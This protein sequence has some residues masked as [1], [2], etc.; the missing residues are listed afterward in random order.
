MTF[1]F[2]L[3]VLV[4]LVTVAMHLVIDLGLKKMRRLKDVEVLSGSAPAVTVI[5]PACNEADTIGP[6]LNSI[7]ALEYPDLEIIV[8]NDRSTDGTGQVLQDLQK[9]F[10]QL[11]IL[12][13]SELPPGWLG[14]NHALHVAAARSGGDFLLFT[15]ADV[16]FEK[17]S[18]ARAMHHMLTERLDH[19]S[20]VFENTACGGLLNAL[21]MDAGGGLLLL[22]RPWLARETKSRRYMGVGAFNLVKKSVYQRIGGHQ[23]IAM[24]PIDDIMLG[25]LIKHR[26]F[27]QDCLLGQGFVSVRWYGTVHEFI[28][29]L[30]KN[31]FAVYNYSVAKA[32]ATV[33]V[34]F[35]LNG[36][37]QLGLLFAEGGTRSFFAAT[38]AV[39]FLSFLRGA[40]QTDISPWYTPWTLVSPYIIAYT[41]IKATFLTLYNR[42]IYWRGTFYP[43]DR[44][45]AG[46]L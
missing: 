11:R 29:G 14:K 1:L 13:I 42:G 35:L 44:L 19:M 34:L 12:N 2:W 10:P 17:T 38:L 27:R 41:I 21:I 9:R 4:F 46:R 45:K 28:N 36:L 24:H 22:Y 40:A 16:V 20:L 8:V 39:R 32:L 3:A 43:L 31:G 26:G 23:R 37:P 25:K 18:L 30:M 15:D 6:A 33:V 7:L 5:I